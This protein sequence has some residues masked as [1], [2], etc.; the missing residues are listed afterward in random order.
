MAGAGRAWG[1]REVCQRRS[2]RPYPRLLR[3]P[4]SPWRSPS[5]LCGHGHGVVGLASVGNHGSPSSVDAEAAP[6]LCGS[7]ASIA[8]LPSVSIVQSVCFLSVVG[9]AW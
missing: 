1:A 4:S 8:R 7:F 6:R 2:R 3:G 5:S 9:R